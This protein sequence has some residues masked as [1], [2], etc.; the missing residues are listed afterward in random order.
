MSETTL[1]TIAKWLP[2]IDLAHSTSGGAPG[3]GGGLGGVGGVGGGDGVGEM[4]GHEGVV[5]DVLVLST[6]RLASARFLC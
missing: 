5:Q 1:A 6:L 4:G 2:P 3:R